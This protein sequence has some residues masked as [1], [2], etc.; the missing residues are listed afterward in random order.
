[1]GFHNQ[2][3]VML[4]LRSGN[5]EMSVYDESTV[6]YTPF[7]PGFKLMFCVA[8]CPNTDSIGK[9]QI[10]QNKNKDFLLI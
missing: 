10:A 9:K 3:S 7:H 8:H 4:E 5:E 2:I 1:M 6:K